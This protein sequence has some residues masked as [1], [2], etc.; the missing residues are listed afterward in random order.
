MSFVGPRPEVADYV[1]PDDP[2]WREVLSVRPGLTDPVTLRL[3]HEEALLES[4]AGDRER[5]YRETLQP[6][7]LE[8][9]VAYLR[10]RSWI[11]D[12]AVLAATAGAILRP[13]SLD[14]GLPDGPADRRT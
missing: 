2:L 1:H 3:R 4:V 6:R 13:R 11:S 12:L 10:R 14:R 7:K 5:Y 9:Y 8:G